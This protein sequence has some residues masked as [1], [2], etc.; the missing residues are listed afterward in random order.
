MSFQSMAILYVRIRRLSRAVY[1]KEP[2]NISPSGLSERLRPLYITP[3]VREEPV[4]R[5]DARRPE[6]DNIGRRREI[7][8]NFRFIFALTITSVEK[9]V[10]IVQN[11]FPGAG[12]VTR[13]RV[14]CRVGSVGA[15]GRANKKD[16]VNVWFTESG[17]GAL[18]SVHGCRCRRSASPRSRREY[19]TIWAR[20]SARQYRPRTGSCL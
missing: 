18:F 4:T 3:G 6:P 19:G 5:R 13:C 1:I 15:T 16:P 8:Y 20:S 12:T 17:R 10:E 9:P 11:S 7:R 14:I 2:P